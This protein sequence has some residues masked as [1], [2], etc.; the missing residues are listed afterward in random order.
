VDDLLDLQQRFNQ[1]V[2]V[3]LRKDGDG[4]EG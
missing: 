2:E 1:D 4:N 3:H